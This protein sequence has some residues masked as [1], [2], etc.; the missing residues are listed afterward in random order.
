VDE[1]KHNNASWNYEREF[2]YVMLT[3]FIYLSIYSRRGL[4][5]YSLRTKIRCG[6][7]LSWTAK[8]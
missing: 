2:D 3:N 4:L 7:E 6:K 1:G 8:T 5:K